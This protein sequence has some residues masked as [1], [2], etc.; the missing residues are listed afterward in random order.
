MQ[1]SDFKLNDLKAD[2]A[3]SPQ[4]KLADVTE[5]SEQDWQQHLSKE[6]YQVCRLAQTEKPFSGELVF[7]QETGLYLCH[8]C[9][10]PLF[11]SSNKYQSHCGWPTFDA[12]LSPQCLVYK[13]DTRF[14]QHRIEVCCARCDSH[15]GHLFTDGPRHTTG[16]R[17][18][19]NSIALD[20]EPPEQDA[21]KA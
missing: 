3:T 20:F 14:N 18:C 1:D 15:I 4:P 2:G 13:E 5:Y 17:Y 16:E 7:H 8:C 9:H 6:A 11:D 10:A 12:P 21:N 19:V